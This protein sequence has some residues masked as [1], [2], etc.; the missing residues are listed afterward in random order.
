MSPISSQ[1]PFIEGVVVVIFLLKVARSA[2]PRR[3]QNQLDS[4]VHPIP[5]SPA[6]TYAMP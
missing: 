6:I 5:D 1:T 3:A 2:K 4:A